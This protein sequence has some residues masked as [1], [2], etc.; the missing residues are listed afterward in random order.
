[1]V[2]KVEAK[3]PSPAVIEKPKPK[4]TLL[5]VPLHVRYGFQNPIDVIDWD[6]GIGTYPGFPGG[7]VSKL[8]IKFR[9]RF[10]CP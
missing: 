8:K 1:M 2:E 4:P 6:G 7:K 9:G 5:H 3:I 10:R